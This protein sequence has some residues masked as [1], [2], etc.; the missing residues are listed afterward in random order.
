MKYGVSITDECISWDT[1]E[2][3]ILSAHEQLLAHNHEQQKSS[4]A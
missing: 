2:E 3:L 4:A 1:T